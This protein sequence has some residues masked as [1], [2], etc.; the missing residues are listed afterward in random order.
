MGPRIADAA[1]L[2]ALTLLGIVTA[3]ADDQPVVDATA[4]IACHDDPSIAAIARTP[5]GVVADPA[6]P[7]AQEHC[8]SCH[9][10]AAEH[11]Q[12]QADSTAFRDIDNFGRAA[13][14]LEE[15]QSD[16]CLDC[17]AQHIDLAW[18]GSVHA[19]NDANCADCHT[20]HAEKDPVLSKAGQ[21]DV[22]Y[23][24]H[25][26]LEAE[27]WKPSIHPIR[28]AKMTCSDCHDAHASVTDALLTKPTLNQLCY[29]CHAE[30]RGPFLW[31]HA[32]VAEDC[33]LCHRPHGSIHPALLTTRGPLLC[34]Q[35][36]SS[37]GHPSV[38]L[39][40]SSLPG[41]QPSALLLNQNCANCH[42]QVHG[43]NH[44]SGSKLMR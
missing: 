2:I 37:A 10:G 11:A 38:A 18:R 32:P 40:T 16:V 24:C 17:H 36:H 15:V 6:S 25:L 28:F 39:T 13:A 35:C 21:P 34:Q 20:V 3:L 41:G 19:V 22:C 4:C 7:A 23:A 29:D 43:S 8:G 27:T 12:R 26:E 14:T 9:K 33:S 30:K 44:P 42:V 31:E 1:A 5:H